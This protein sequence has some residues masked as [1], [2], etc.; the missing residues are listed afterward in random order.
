MKV[1]DSSRRSD[2]LAASVVPTVVLCLV[3][4]FDQGHMFR[5]LPTLRIDPAPPSK[6]FVLPPEP[7]E[8]TDTPE[9]SRTRDVVDPV[10]QIP[11]SPQPIRWNSITQ[12]IEPP[13]PEGPINDTIK[14]PD[15]WGPSG[16]RPAVFDPSMLDQQPTTRFQA[17]PVYPS[18]MKQEGISGSVLVDF[19]VDSEG[20]VRNAS[21]V[22]FTTPD[23][24][25]SAVSAV[26][27]WKFKP[28]RRAG[29]AVSTH[30][31]VPIEFTLNSPDQ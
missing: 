13:V 31:Q 21:A 8:M 27:R 25:A 12:P 9:P 15:K 6:R 26:S 28:G 7:V 24:A 1:Y 4:W 3:V 14:I 10:P 19:I 30:L 11:D 20:D 18:K 23:F 29:H 2:I 16:P 22:R 5:G 17:K